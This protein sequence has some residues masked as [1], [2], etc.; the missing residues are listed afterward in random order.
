MDRLLLAVEVLWQEELELRYYDLKRMCQINEEG[1]RLAAGRPDSESYW[2]RRTVDIQHE[3][4]VLKNV[5][6]ALDEARRA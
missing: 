5:R 1:L 2:Q 3:F 4:S 6:D